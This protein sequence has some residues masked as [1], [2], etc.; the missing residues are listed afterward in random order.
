MFELVD[1]QIFWPGDRKIDFFIFPDQCRT[2]VCCGEGY[3][4]GIWEPSWRV[5]VMKVC[6][7]SGIR[8]EEIKTGIGAKDDLLASVS[9]RTDDCFVRGTARLLAR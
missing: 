7:P 1:R 8:A 9:F 4:L 2:I 6:R 5:K 3:P